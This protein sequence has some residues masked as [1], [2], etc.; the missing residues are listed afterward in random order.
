LIGNAIKFTHYGEVVVHCCVDKEQLD[1]DDLLLKISVRDTGIGMSEEEI[2]G[3]FL[4]FSQVD[5][6]TTR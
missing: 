4:P 6:S 5:G 3:L 2:K 1:D